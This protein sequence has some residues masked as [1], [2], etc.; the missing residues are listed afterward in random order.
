[1]WRG[2]GGGARWAFAFGAFMRQEAVRWG[3][4]A[5]GASAHLRCVRAPM[6]TNDFSKSGCFRQC[7]RTPMLMRIDAS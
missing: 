3:A 1:V 4:L 7:V 5:D 6:V 2:V